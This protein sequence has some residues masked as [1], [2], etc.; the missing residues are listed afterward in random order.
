MPGWTING[1]NWQNADWTDVAVVR[2][3]WKAC[4][5]RIRCYPIALGSSHSYFKLPVAGGDIQGAVATSPNPTTPTSTTYQQDGSASDTWYWQELQAVVAALCTQFVATSLSWDG[6]TDNS[7][8][9]L[10]FGDVMS[11]ISG[12]ER[13]HFRRVTGTNLPADWTDFGDAAYSQGLM[14]V[15]DVIGPWIM[16]DLQAVLNKL[17]WTVQC[18]PD[19]VDTGWFDQTGQQSR[20]ASASDYDVTWDAIW[21]TMATAW[22]AASWADNA[23]G[24]NYQPEAEAQGAWTD[25]GGYYQIQAIAQRRRAYLRINNMYGDAG[26]TCDIDWYVWTEKPPLTNLVFDGEALAYVTEGTWEWLE[27]QTD[28]G[29]TSST[30]A[31]YVGDLSAVPPKPASPIG[32]SPTAKGWQI[33]GVTG[34][35]TNDGVPVVI[36]K[37]LD[38]EFT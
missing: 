12:G 7:P 38:L 28:V 17:R 35:P 32:S 30:T 33:K 25:F 13:T 18:A 37:W 8:A 36:C 6:S 21:S 4:N 15:G 23:G 11:E 1:I 16:Y 24:S 31:T 20:S 10:V 9:R 2:Q 19:H 29:A 5:E 34:G 22:A 14:Q 3:L 26:F 27:T